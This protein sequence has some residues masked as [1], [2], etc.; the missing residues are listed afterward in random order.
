MTCANC[1]SVVCILGGNAFE[2][3]R[4]RS[5]PFL[6]MRSSVA[7]VRVAAWINIQIAV[8]GI[9]AKGD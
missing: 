8:I 5:F 4:P 1:S 3:G 7:E 6:G 2:G 9:I